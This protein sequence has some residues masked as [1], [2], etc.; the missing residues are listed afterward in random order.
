MAAQCFIFF[1][2]GFETSSAAATFA[3]YELALHQ[4]IQ[5]KVRDEMETAIK[6]YNGELTYEGM[7]EMVY[8]KQIMDGKFN[9]FIR[10]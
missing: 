6:K 3:L 2:A 9:E 10:I 5:D 1:A 4:D 8:M 7:N